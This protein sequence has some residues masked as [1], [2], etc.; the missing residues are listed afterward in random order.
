MPHATL[1]RSR[2]RSQT[3]THTQ[4]HIIAET[5][6]ELEWFANLANTNP[7]RTE[8]TPPVSPLFACSGQ[9]GMLRI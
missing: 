5:P 1:T 4:Y 6:Q 2:A 7:R 9:A 8:D 3:P